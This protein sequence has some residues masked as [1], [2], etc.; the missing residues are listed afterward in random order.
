LTYFSRDDAQKVLARGSI[1]K[2][3]N[4]Y[5]SVS[6]YSNKIKQRL[7]SVIS[8]TESENELVSS[9]SDNTLSNLSVIINDLADDLSPQQLL[10]NDTNSVSKSIDKKRILLTNVPVGSIS[11]EYLVLY[12][13]YLNNNNPRIELDRYDLSSEITNTLLVT[14]KSPIGNFFFILFKS[15]IQLI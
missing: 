3:D 7:E 15:N 9:S 5:L 10:V 4:K 1:F 13:E 11:E 8:S 6:R 2:L 14:F 12:L